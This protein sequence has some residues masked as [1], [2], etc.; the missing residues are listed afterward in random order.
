MPRKPAPTPPSTA[1][2]KPGFTYK[3]QFGVIVICDSERQQRQVYDALAKRHKK[4][5]VVCT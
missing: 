1:K 5:K 3:P 4:V 2:P